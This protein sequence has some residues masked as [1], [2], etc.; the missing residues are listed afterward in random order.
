MTK[1]HRWEERSGVDC[2]GGNDYAGAGMG[3]T[4]FWDTQGV[5]I[6]C[7]TTA[8][9]PHEISHDAW[10]WVQQSSQPSLM[11]LTRYFSCPE[12]TVARVTG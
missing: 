7:R 3:W 12:L 4:V 5:L 9:S 8:A 2:V 6:G 10:A 1:S 11:W